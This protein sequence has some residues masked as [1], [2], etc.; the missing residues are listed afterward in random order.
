MH[1]LPHLSRNI[2]PLYHADQVTKPLLV[3]QGSND[4]RVLQV[5]SDE[6]FAAVRNHGVPVEDIL[7]EDEGHGFVKKEIQIEGYGKALAFLEKHLSEHLN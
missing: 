7:F 3:L 2:S 5:E 4:P 6:I 1:V